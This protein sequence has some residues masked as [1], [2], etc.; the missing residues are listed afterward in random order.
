MRLVKQ[1][2]R[3]T[4]QFGIIDH[5]VD[6]NRLGHNHNPGFGRDLAVEP[7]QITDRFAG[8]FAQ[9]LRHSFGRCARRNPSR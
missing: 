7:G 2:G 4:G 9:H 3:N 8:F 1:H 6:E 5:P